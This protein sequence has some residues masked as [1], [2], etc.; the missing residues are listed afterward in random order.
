MKTTTML[1]KKSQPGRRMV[2]KGM[3]AMLTAVMAAS[4]SLP[5]YAADKTIRVGIMSGEDEDVWR[6]VAQEAAKQGL[7]IK[8]VTFNDY[9]QPNEALERGDLDANSFQHLP[10]L[11]NQ[12]KTQGYKIVPVG[13]TAVWPIGLYSK[14]FTSV[15]D[16]PKGATIGI[17]NDPANEARALLV[18][19]NEGV[20]KLKPGAGIL[21]TTVDIV[22]NPKNIKIK[23]L[24][25]GVVGRAIDDL[26]AAVVNTDWASKA[27]LTPKERIAQ[28]PVKDNPYR[29]F[30]AVREASKNEAWVKPLVAAYQTKAVDEALLK[31]W[32]GAALP[33]Y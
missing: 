3:A 7:T 5:A 32:K 17:P 29:C 8:V 2:M 11:E 20:I 6:V 24:D 1:E 23:E 25:A 9:I 27:G 31:A 14:T 33:A 21:A 28:E 13:Y 19:Q 12:I 15:A 4:V 16:L 26:N 30:I 10:Y 22:E 18:L